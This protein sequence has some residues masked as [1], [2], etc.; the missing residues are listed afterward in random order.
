LSS[1][2]LVFLYFYADW[3]HFCRLEKAIIDEL[4]SIYSGKVVFI[5][6]N[7]ARNK[8]ALEEFGVTGFPTMFLVYGKRGSVYL[9][10]D[11][12]GFKDKASL[13]SAIAK[14]VGGD[15][16]VE[17]QGG[18]SQ[19]YNSIGGLFSHESCNFWDCVSACKDKKEATL[20]ELFRELVEAVTGCLDPSI[21]TDVYSCGKAIITN[22][23]DDWIGCAS[24][25]LPLSKSVSCTYSISHALAD[26]FGAKQWGECLGECA[27]DPSSYGQ[28]CQPGEQTAACASV[29]GF[30]KM[31]ECS[32]DCEWTY[33][34]GSVRSCGIGEEC[35]TTA[36]GAECRDEDDYDPPDPFLP[37]PHPPNPPGFDQPD[38]NYDVSTLWL[39]APYTFSEVTSDE[40][41][42]PK[43]AVLNRGYPLIENGL[44]S[45][46]SY[47]GFYVRL[48]SLSYL[49]VINPTEYP[50]LVIPSGVFSLYMVQGGLDPTS[51]GMSTAVER[52]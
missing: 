33:V 41:K 21:V 39:S 25:L 4:E 48:L 26:L 44:A 34:P 28:V 24:S 51:K 10:R 29:S 7:E 45:F 32:S 8:L 22:E 43:I 31:Q 16:H 37:P 6:I 9:Y 30:I 15:F 13:E 18:N 12:R 50:V 52:S 17:D 36:N 20:D 46:L 3:C 14:M 2:R 27:A 35:V 49:E 5:R 11:F 47:L 42:K 38:E 23:V 1:G 19:C 40:E